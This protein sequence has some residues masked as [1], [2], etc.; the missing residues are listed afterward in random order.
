M[1]NLRLKPQIKMIAYCSTK[2]NPNQGIARLVLFGFLLGTFA[3]SSSKQVTQLSPETNPDVPNATLFTYGQDSVTAEDFKYVY[4]KNNQDIAAD[5]S[6]RELEESIREYLE[7]YVNFKLKVKAAYQAGLDRESAFIKEFNQ[8]KNQLAK[9]YMVENRYKENLI[10]EAYQRMKEEVRASHI[11]ISIP[12]GAEDTLRYY[13]KADSLRQLAEAGAS[14]AMLAEE[15]S[16]DPSAAQN[17]GNLG[18][19]S[20][21]QMVYPFENAAFNTAVGSVSRPVRTQ[22]GYHIIKVHDKRPSQGKVKVAHI[23]IRHQ[24]GEPMDETSPGY[25]RAQEI[26][27]DL[28]SGADWKELAERYSE[29]VSTRA[30]GGELPYFG[31]GGM[32]KPFEQAAF[33]IEEEGQVSQPVSTR[34][35]WHLIKLLDKKGLEPLDE[36]RPSIERKVDRVIQLAEM[37]GDMIDM[38]RKENGFVGRK[39][40]IE[41]AIQYLQS[42]TEDAAPDE[43]SVLFVLKD[44]SF[45]FGDFKQ[46]LQDKNIKPPLSADKANEVYT[47]Y[48]EKMIV[49]NEESHLTEKYP[50]FKLLLQEYKEGILLFNIM[51]RRVWNKANE[52][53]EGLNTFYASKLSDYQWKR[54]VDATIFE[55]KKPETIDV[56]KSKLQSTNVTD[57][58]ITEVTKELQQSDAR[59]VQKYRG[60]YEEGADLNVAESVIQDLDWEQNRHE[61]QAHEM[62]YY[63]LIHELMEPRAKSLEEVKG[64]VIADYQRQLDEEW[65]R[66]LRAKYP[67]TVDE[68]VLKKLTQNIEDE[69]K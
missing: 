61:V 14:F 56:I 50:D 19:F 38:L 13:Q 10:H 23:M 3:C 55:A 53:T 69:N 42:S 26:Y 64:L 30:N 60:V 44:A 24:Q 6:D 57:E 51:E 18:Y 17:G 7:L 58:L 11:L 25:A 16:E 59:S 54:R 21:L 41:K 47:G 9:P 31:T 65:V 39:V 46:Y 27:E 4:L 63:I 36:L 66:E 45:N 68:T 1:Q 40:N 48:E 33:A 67:V 43:K 49:D 62:Y 15:N 20:A 52:D 5:A 35:G 8:Y 2:C 34:Y 22:Y 32:L 28:Q 37:Q 29:D 12:D